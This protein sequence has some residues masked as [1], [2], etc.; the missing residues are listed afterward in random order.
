MARIKRGVV[1]HGK[2][3]KLLN[4]AKGYR[5][6]RNRLIKVASEAVLHAGEY[7]FQ[8]RKQRKREM[9]S[10]WIIR[11][12]AALRA[13][14]IKYSAFINMMKLKKVIVDRKIL[15]LLAQ[16]EKTFAAFVKEIAS[17]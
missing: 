1:S 10:L 13:M 14:G 7:A 12:N 17:S 6:T 4:L 15:A 16:N 5:M 3:K 9:R 2:H 11:I 8:G